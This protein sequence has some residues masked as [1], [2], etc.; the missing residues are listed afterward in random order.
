MRYFV[1]RLI[2][3]QLIIVLCNIRE[4]IVKSQAQY[5]CRV[6]SHIVFNPG[7]DVVRDIEW[8]DLPRSFLILKVTY[9]NLFTDNKLWINPKISKRQLA[10]TN[11]FFILDPP[12]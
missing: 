8:L 5:H 6:P 9:I 3:R 11:R 7:D 10:T 1:F 2:E 12:F 4:I